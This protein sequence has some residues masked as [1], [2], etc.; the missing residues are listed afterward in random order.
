M[1]TAKLRLLDQLTDSSV[2]CS[3]AS[4]DRHGPRRWITS[5]L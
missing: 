1:T 3:T 5:A 4:R 2:A